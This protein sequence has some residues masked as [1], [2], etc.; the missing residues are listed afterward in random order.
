MG[1]GRETQSTG[2]M[3]QVF[4]FSST[5]AS[6]LRYD[7]ATAIASGRTVSVSGHYEAA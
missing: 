7:N 4:Q 5:A 1:H 2:A 3:L 6:I